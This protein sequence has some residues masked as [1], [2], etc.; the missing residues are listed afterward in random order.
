MMS[1]KAHDDDGC[2]DDDDGEG[3]ISSCL[4]LVCLGMYA[5]KLQLT[6]HLNIL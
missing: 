1:K 6:K 5:P 4:I 2:D 3:G